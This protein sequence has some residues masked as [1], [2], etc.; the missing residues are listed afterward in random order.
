MKS[1]MK[2]LR[3]PWYVAGMVIGTLM[4][5][6]IPVVG[7]IIIALAWFK[8]FADLKKVDQLRRTHSTSQKGDYPT[9]PDD[10]QRGDH[11][12][13]MPFHHAD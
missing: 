7:W 6:G 1:Y 5:V 4:C 12:S 13:T 10:Q 11:Y 8:Y 3:K 9:I 2:H